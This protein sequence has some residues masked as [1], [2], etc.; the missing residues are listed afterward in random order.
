MRKVLDNLFYQES[1]WIR[2]LEKLAVEDTMYTE[3]HPGKVFFL[4]QQVKFMREANKTLTDIDPS[5]AKLRF[6]SWQNSQY[7]VRAHTQAVIKIIYFFYQVYLF[8]MYMKQ[9]LLMEL[10]LVSLQ[11]DHLFRKES[12]RFL[13]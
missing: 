8:I 5:A 10:L 11:D 7:H 6:K 12:W 1:I 3:R 9:E 13:S 4:H 2:F